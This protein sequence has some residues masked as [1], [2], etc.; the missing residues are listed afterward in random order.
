MYLI[1]RFAIITCLLVIA[2]CVGADQRL[3]IQQ[4]VPDTAIETGSQVDGQIQLT[5]NFP[6]TLPVDTVQPWEEMSNDGKVISATGAASEF[7]AGT[8]TDSTSGDTSSWNGTLRM[9]SGD[10]G[11]GE[12]SYAMYRI[13]LGGRAPRVVSVDANL[14]PMIDG[15]LGG[16]YV[17]LADYGNNS[18]QWAI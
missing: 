13:P 17:G 5:Q 1:T 7:N 8:Q 12:L 11:G 18:W 2:G 3:P 4:Q 14:R 10:S 6:T 9:A 16:Y 15:S